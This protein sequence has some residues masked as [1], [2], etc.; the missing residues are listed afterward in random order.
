MAF[1]VRTSQPTR[2]SRW[3][4]VSSIHLLRGH[5]DTK[6]PTAVNAV[7]VADRPEKVSERV[8]LVDL[9]WI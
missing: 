5:T 4:T 6:R 9:S 3:L 8:Q 7:A 2:V 1:Q